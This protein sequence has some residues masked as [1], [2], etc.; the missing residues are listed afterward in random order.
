MCVA[1][2]TFISTFFVLNL[3]LLVPKT[4]QKLQRDDETQI[5]W[6][7]FSVII[8]VI[9]SVAIYPFIFCIGG[10]EVSK[11]YFS[12]V[13]FLSQTMGFSVWSWKQ[14]FIPLLHAMILYLGPMITFF[15]RHR[16]LYILRSHRG[17]SSKQS[18]GNILFKTMVSPSISSSMSWINFR[19]LIIAPLAEEV[20]FRSCI[21]TPFLYTEAYY[22][23]AISLSTI[24]WCTPL[25]FGFAHLHHVLRRLQEGQ[26]SVKIIIFTSSFQFIYTTIFGAYASFCYIK[27]RSLFG[28]VIL[29]SFCN[30][31][32]LPSVGFFFIKSGNL[33][34]VKICKVIGI[35]AYII[36]IVC[37]Y[38]GFYALP[39]T[40]A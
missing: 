20:T 7:I 23:K 37:F 11:E 31:M 36:G 2:A 33:L 19:N 35:I 27:T 8:T 10:D 22:N 3:Y 1:F 17:F 21:V 34:E 9:C 26:D 30:Y 12:K 24:C 18:Y 16:S 4:V 39:W 29:H 6:R 14:S 28:V 25:F 40:Q 38:F 5:K 32:G 15:L 13:K